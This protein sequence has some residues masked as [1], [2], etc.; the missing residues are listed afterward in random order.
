MPAQLLS[1]PRRGPDCA[2]SSRWNDDLGPDR[3]V[4]V[5][6]LSLSRR[7]ER[8]SL[9]RQTCRHQDSQGRKKAETLARRGEGDAGTLLVCWQ[10]HVS[11]VEAM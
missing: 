6:C 11:F 5:P 3:L 9:I 10:V 8:P 1:V 7:E 2:L 4:R